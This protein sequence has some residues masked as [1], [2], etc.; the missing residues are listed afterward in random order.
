MQ[1]I[2][3][4]LAA[5]LVD[6]SFLM[7]LI[8]GGVWDRDLRHGENVPGNTN[9]A[10]YISPNDPRR[11]LRL[12][13]TIVVKGGN[14]VMAISGPIQSEDFELRNT[15]LRLYIYVPANAAGKALLDQIDDRVRWLINGWS[16]ILANGNA[17]TFNFV[18]LTEPLEVEEPI[19]GY[20]VSERRVVGEY[21]RPYH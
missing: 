5:R 9:D 13:P 11:I 21:L 19:S 18:D 8:P 15:F 7:G 20:L 3:G 2:R 12:H 1:E 14:D 17:V 6:D 16:T 10:F 4:K